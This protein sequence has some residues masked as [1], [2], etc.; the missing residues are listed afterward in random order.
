MNYC[1]QYRDLRDKTMT[2]E[3]YASAKQDY[4][5]FYIGRPLSYWLTIPFLKTNLTPNQVSYISIIPILIGFILMT[6]GESKATLIVGWLMFFLWNLLDG[7]DGN[8]ARYRKNFSKD[9]SVIDAMAGYASM[10]FTFLSAGIAASN[11]N[12]LNLEPKYFIVLG[13]LSSMSLLFPRLIMHKY[14]NT[15]GEDNASESVKDKK[16]FSPL[17][18]LALNLTSITGL[19]QVFLFIS[20]LMSMLDYFTIIYFFINCSI[21]LASL[22]SLLKSKGD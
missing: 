9:G 16:A 5:A 21:M 19:P 20:I 17:K 4:F 14:I 12:N 8:L 1:E 6:F 22:Y 7:V 13:A 11:Y 10:A 3:K 18:I 15:V 2:P